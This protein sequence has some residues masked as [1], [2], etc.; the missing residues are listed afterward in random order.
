MPEELLSQK[1]GVKERGGVNGGGS[2]HLLSQEGHWLCDDIAFTIPS[3]RSYSFYTFNI[4][5]KFSRWVHNTND[6]NN[7]N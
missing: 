4:R 1:D 7:N 3:A 6:I 2:T 5:M